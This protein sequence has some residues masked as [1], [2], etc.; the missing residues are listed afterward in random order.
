MNEKTVKETVKETLL[1]QLELLTEASQAEGVKGT[2]EQVMF[3]NAILS[4]SGIL[5]PYF[6]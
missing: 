6:E 2:S 5:L 1:K 4:I 3:A